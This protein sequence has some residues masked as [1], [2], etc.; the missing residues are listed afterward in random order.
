MRASA[1]AAG[2]PGSSPEAVRDLLAANRAAV[3]GADGLS[4]ALGDALDRV[5]TADDAIGQ[6]PSAADLTRMAELVQAATSAHAAVTALEE[7]TEQTLAA[8]TAGLAQQVETARELADELPRLLPFTGQAQRA[9]LTAQLDQ[10]SQAVTE[11]P[12]SQA[13]PQPGTGA[14]GA[15]SDLGPRRQPRPR[16]GD[17]ADD[18]GQVRGRIGRA[19]TGHPPPGGGRGRRPWPAPPG[20]FAAASQDADLAA[21]LDDAATELESRRPSWWPAPRG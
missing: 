14:P 16:R 18:G 13:R 21:R 12:A 8:A 10:A 2:P 5:A 7:I 11:L 9:A 3:P 4:R 6:A 1:S 20:R 15:G 19:A 17:R